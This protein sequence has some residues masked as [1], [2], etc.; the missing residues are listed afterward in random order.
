MIAAFS[1]PLASALVA[2]VIISGC[3][4]DITDNEVVV[5]P[6]RVAQVGDPEALKGRVFPGQAKATQEVELSFRVKGPLIAL[7]VKIGDRVKEGDVLARIDPRDFEVQ[8]RNTQGQLQRAEA[9]L[10]RADSE[11]QRLLGVQAKNPELVSEVAVERARE[12]FELGK[13]D[14]AALEA[15]VEAAQD[16]LDYTYLKAP[17]DGTIVA[18]YVENFEY[19]VA[20]QAVLRLLDNTHIEFQFSVPENLISLIQ[21]V[22]NIRVHYDAFPDLELAAEL[23]EI[24]TEA[25]QTTRTYPITLIMDQP[26]GV[27]ILPGMAGKA[28]GDAI[29]PGQGEQLILVVP[30]AAIFSP[31]AG[32]EHYVWVIDPDAN[33]V[34]RREVELGSLV[35]SGISIQSGLNPGEL[36][37][38][39]GV[40]FLEEGQQVRPIIE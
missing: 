31:T 8:L 16:A 28:F 36:I 10:D 30:N 13:A 19:V 7:P 34:S 4:S 23:K 24:G 29:I 27:E 1:K 22:Q 35:S 33:T 6:I 40:H 14:K 18:N 11:Y 32:G 12:A 21:Q 26:E 38:T 9:N 20:R 17:Y 37:A 25:S 2:L 39:A 3:E 5:R 15:T